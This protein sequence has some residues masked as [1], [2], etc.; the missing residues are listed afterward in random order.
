MYV[1]AA[2]G[3]VFML[4]ALGIPFGSQLKQLKLNG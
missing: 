2:R 4:I 1:D 3:V